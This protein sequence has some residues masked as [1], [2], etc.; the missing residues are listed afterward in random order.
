MLKKTTNMVIWLFNDYT[1]TKYTI[2]HNR[3]QDFLKKFQVN[4]NKQNKRNKPKTQKIQ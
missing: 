2:M 4:P 1:R 3:I